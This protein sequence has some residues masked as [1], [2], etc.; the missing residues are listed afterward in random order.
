MS[1]KLTAVILLLALVVTAM[2]SACGE[3]SE[4]I[5][6]DTAAAA[7]GEEET[8]AEPEETD[9]FDA[10]ASVSDGL[11]E[12][13]YDGRRFYILG[14]NE[15]QVVY[16][17]AEE[18]NG[19]VMNDALS[20][21]NLAI[22][23]RFNVAL[24][25]DVSKEMS[26]AASYVSKCTLA[27]E[28]AV[29]LIS[30]HVVTV[31]GI[32]A[33]DIVLNWYDIPYVDF[34]KPWWSPSNI[35]DLTYNHVALLAM[36]SYAMST[37]AVTFCMFFNK[38]L[39]DSYGIP[40][41]YE[42]VNNGQWTIDKL[43]ETVNDV[44]TDL[45]GNSERDKDDF[46]GITIRA[47]GTHI[48]AFQWAFDNPVMVKDGTGRPTLA[49]NNEKMSVMLVKLCDLMHNN[50]GAI[51]N[52]DYSFYCNKFSNGETIFVLG[53][54]YDSVN[55]FR[56]MEDNF[57]LIPYPKL[58]EEQPAYKTM[59]NGCHEAM[60][61]SKAVSDPEYIGIITEA[62]CAETYKTVEPVY[63]DIVLKLKGARDEISIDMLDMIMNSR[64]FDFGFIY[65]NWKGPSFLL[66]DLAIA[67]KTDYASAYAKKESSYIKHYDAI[68][69]A[70][71]VYMH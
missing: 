26:T 1:K 34:E 19:D 42:T 10:R 21:R 13:D 17:V 7:G 46:Y 29:D 20:P 24:Q 23:E 44:Y 11:P 8:A 48:A 40:D 52:S 63:Y 6:S 45:N 49:A 33:N 47:G 2:A 69:A 71:E 12:K 70:F 61:V 9:V 65:D 15:N 38:R 67:N 68:L 35:N 39:A 32:V 57:G 51:C 53:N 62:L 58:S 37:E 41:L 30:M 4:N 18:E 14:H 3:T 66:Q 25:F 50:T 31:S 5:V 27:G 55:Y 43:S 54:V 60:A 22:E 64:V 28:D 36:G 59:V 16:F 56:D